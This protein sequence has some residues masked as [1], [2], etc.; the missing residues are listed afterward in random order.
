[1]TTVSA[2]D[3]YKT[4]TPKPSGGT[5]V[6]KVA[7]DLQ[8]QKRIESVQRLNASHAATID[9]IKNSITRPNVM[10]VS[11]FGTLRVATDATRIGTTRSAKSSKKGDTKPLKSPH[12]PNRGA[13]GRVAPLR[14][15]LGV[16]PLPVRE[17]RPMHG[18]PKHERSDSLRD[19]PT[20][21][22]RPDH[23][24]GMG[25]SRVFVPWCEKRKH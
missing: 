24:S 9:A 12:E 7:V 1:M 17:A 14:G 25:N 21:K 23:R 19:G 2:L 20:C 16:E 11:D 4:D 5:S 22:P 10:R 18:D 8:R 3:G 15:S 6:K 13:G